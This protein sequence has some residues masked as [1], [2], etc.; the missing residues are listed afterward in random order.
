MTTQELPKTSP[1]R[2]VLLVLLI[3]SADVLL[4]LVAL[5]LGLEDGSVPASPALPELLR[6]AVMPVLAP[7]GAVALIW[8]HRFPRTVAAAA[9]VLGALSFSA[10][11]FFVA[12]FLVARRRLSGWV[13]ALIALSIAA[14]ALLGMAPLTWDVALLMAALLAAVAGWG[15]YRGQRARALA[16]NVAMLQERAQQ[17]EASRAAH[18]ERA[19]LFER[20]R[21]AREM[22]DTLAHRMSL[23]AVQ[24]SALQVA[25][26][27]PD[28]AAAA[29]GIR[30]TAHAALRELRDVLGVLHEDG[31]QNQ[32]GGAGGTALAAPGGM[33]QIPDL[34]EQWREAGLAVDL[35]LDRQSEDDLPEAASRAAFRVVQEG[36]TNVARHAP[37]AQ[38]AVKVVATAQE[39]L[40]TVSNGPGAAGHAVPGAGL[41]LAGLAERV[42]LLGGSLECGP[43]EAG[44]ELAARIPLADRSRA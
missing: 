35:G 7:L 43:T 16:E 44:F 26:S 11:A 17:A 2:T 42:A 6:F 31:T 3:A 33:A 8:R 34:V 19:Q 30:E 18:V 27:N 12:L 23:V 14:E 24:A 36:L 25:A 39:L 28:T 32:N 37:D 13:A 38:A 5:G 10:I 22:H 21:I 15:A 41:G 4:S 9:A 29:R 1:W 40:I 20:Q